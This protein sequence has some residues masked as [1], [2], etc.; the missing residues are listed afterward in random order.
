MSDL[1]DLGVSELSRALAEKSVSSV[2]V[3]THLLA[4]VALHEHLGAWLCTDAEGA[5]KQAAVADT[6]RAQ[7]D[8]GALLGIPLAH[9]DIFVT[10]D[11]PTTAGSKM[12]RGYQSPFDATVV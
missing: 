9:K 6:K 3:T 7:G 10:R 8:T 5:L 11:L 12:L 2:E 1:H 4:R